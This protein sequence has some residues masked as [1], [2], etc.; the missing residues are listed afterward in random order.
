MVRQAAVAG[1]RVP[2]V[3]IASPGVDRPARAAGAAATADAVG[4]LPAEPGCQGSAGPRRR[5]SVLSPAIRNMP[6]TLPAPPA[7]RHP[8]L[9]GAPIA[10]LTREAD[11]AAT[12]RRPLLGAG[13]RTP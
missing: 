13:C 4:R 11:V 10:P 2:A 6:E 3:H 8:H 12:V 9:G 5:P 7:R 1:N